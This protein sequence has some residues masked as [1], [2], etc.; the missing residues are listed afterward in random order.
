MFGEADTDK[1]N[2]EA[3]FDRCDGGVS[4]NDTV[5]NCEQVRIHVP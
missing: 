5:A 3:G 1:L 2:G 4:S